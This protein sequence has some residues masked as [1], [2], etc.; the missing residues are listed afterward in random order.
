MANYYDVL[1]VGKSASKDEIK[2]AYRK[3]AKQYHKLSK[4]DPS[5]QEKLKEINQAYEVLENDQ[6]RATY[7]KY[8]S[9]EFS[10]G[11]YQASPQGSG[12]SGFS[13]F[14]TSSSKEG[15][16]IFDIFDD[17]I[18]MGQTGGQAEEVT[19]RGSDIKYNVNISLEDAFFGI[20]TEIS[21]SA[22]TKCDRCKGSGSTSNT[23]KECHH[24]KGMGTIL[25]QRGFFRLKQTCPHCKG[26]GKVLKDLCKDCS[27]EGRVNRTRKLQVS[28]PKG[29]QS[30]QNIKLTGE[31]EAGTRGAPSGDLFLV[32]SI[33]EHSIFKVK[34]ADLYSR[35]PMR[36]TTAVLG[37]KVRVATISGEDIELKVEPGTQTEQRVKLAGIGMPK[38]RSSERG[39]LFVDLYV[40]VP[41]E[42][43]PKQREFLLKL[44]SFEEGKETED[45]KGFLDKVK[46][47]WK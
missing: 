25:I 40:H 15:L 24:C 19:R 5:A 17:L 28:I 1:G 16:D 45:D 11:A 21:F 37:G 36:F 23:V 32:I 33:K 30:G 2:S 44:A 4:S 42:L 22:G 3:L 8:G 29:V 39:D 35:V 41:K 9:A 18:G 13:G 20:E 6:K 26:S 10:P 7:D 43:T 27:G 46:D 38:L 34:G 12:F 47:I 14:Y 31:G